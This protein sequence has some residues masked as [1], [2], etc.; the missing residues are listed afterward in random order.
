MVVTFWMALGQKLQAEQ[1]KTKILQFSKETACTI[2]VM[3]VG[4][5]QFSFLVQCV[6]FQSKRPLLHHVHKDQ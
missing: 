6:V 1:Y 5:N 2:P 3:Q 4:N